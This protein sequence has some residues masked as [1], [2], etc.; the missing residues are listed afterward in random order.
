MLQAKDWKVQRPERYF[1]QAQS[2]SGETHAHSHT[3]SGHESSATDAEKRVG[4]LC[5]ELRAPAEA[6]QGSFPVE[7]KGKVL[8]GRGKF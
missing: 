7:K 3:P 4:N 6:R 5:A 8:A 1:Q 2:S